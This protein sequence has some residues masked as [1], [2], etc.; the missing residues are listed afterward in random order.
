MKRPLPITRCRACKDGRVVL[1]TSVRPCGECNGTGLCIPHV[2]IAS[3]PVMVR[4]R[5]KLQRLGVNTI[6]DLAA[7][8][9]AGRVAECGQPACSVVRQVRQLVRVF[10]IPVVVGS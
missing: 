6:A 4:T 5:K 1:L 10:R 3:L 8:L 7:F 9:R 2:M